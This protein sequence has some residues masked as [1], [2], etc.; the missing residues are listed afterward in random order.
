MAQSAWRNQ[1]AVAYEQLAKSTK[2]HSVTYQVKKADVFLCQLPTANWQISS[3]PPI[4]F[5][6][7]FQFLFVLI[8]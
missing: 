3:V 6:L 5:S 2:E 7:N 8:P 1:L 4:L